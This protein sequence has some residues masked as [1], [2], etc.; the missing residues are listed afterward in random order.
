MTDPKAYPNGIRFTMPMK[1]KADAEP[2]EFVCENHGGS[3]ERI[4]RTAATPAVQVPVATLSGYVGTYDL[5]EEA[6]GSK[7]V[8]VITLDGATLSL[9][10]DAKGKEA[11]IPLS[12][13]RFSWSGSVLEFV[14]GA[15]GSPEMLM[16]YAEGDERGPRR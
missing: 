11:L 15:G 8:A 10:Y 3:R 2:I 12:P 9:D 6:N 14:T 5:V 13:T 7:T 16:H 1:F 4:S